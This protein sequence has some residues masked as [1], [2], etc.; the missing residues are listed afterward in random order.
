MSLAGLGDSENKNRS[1][2]EATE[3]DGALSLQVAKRMFKW[4]AEAVG[5]GLEL[6]NV[7]E[8]PKD[9]SA[10]QKLLITHVGE[11][12]LDTALD[13][14]VDLFYFGFTYTYNFQCD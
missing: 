13:G 2:I 14:W 10:L 1:E 12:Y 4:L 5:R 6:S 9:V 11:I 3:S 8:T 7:S